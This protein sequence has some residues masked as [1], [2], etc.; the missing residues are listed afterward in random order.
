M[1]LV[2]Q[3]ADNF[4]VEVFHVDPF[5]AFLSVLLLLLFQNQLNEELLKFF[6]TVVDAKLKRKYYL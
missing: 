1:R 6:V 2:D 5:D 3:L 4:V